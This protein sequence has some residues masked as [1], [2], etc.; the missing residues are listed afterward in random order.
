MKF[1]PR[2]AKSEMNSSTWKESCKPES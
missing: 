2:L 1:F